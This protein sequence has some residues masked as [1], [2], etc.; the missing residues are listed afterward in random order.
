M[1]VDFITRRSEIRTGMSSSE[2]QTSLL[3][4]NYNNDCI[5]RMAGDENE[6]YQHID[7]EQKRLQINNNLTKSDFRYSSSEYTGKSHR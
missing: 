1:C 7:L 3:Q 6:F 5:H 4:L 2:T